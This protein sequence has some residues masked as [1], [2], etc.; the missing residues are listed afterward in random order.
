MRNSIP[1]YFSQV[2]FDEKFGTIKFLELWEQLEFDKK[3]KDYESTFLSR[4]EKSTDSKVLFELEI[5]RLRCDANK[6]YYR[7][8]IDYKI[9]GY[10]IAV[11]GNNPKISDLLANRAGYLFNEYHDYF[12][13]DEVL[14]INKEEIIKDLESELGK[15]P[16]VCEGY[17][18]A[19][20]VEFLRGKE[21][22]INIPNFENRTESLPEYQFK[23]IAQKIAWLHELGILELILQKAN[24]NYYIAA[25]I[26]HSYTD[27]KTDTI[28]KGLEAIYKPNEKNRKNNP[29]NNPDNRLFIDEMKR[30]FKL[31]KEK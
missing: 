7:G 5:N 8:G 16:Y 22:E 9:L 18:R 12:E 15:L 30:K 11:D 17:L 31:D 1:K 21:R 13:D 6:Y 4:L 23:T 29:L 2:Y 26:I 20:Q 28:R 14:K 24:D 10:L 3:L 27:L 19:K 25:N